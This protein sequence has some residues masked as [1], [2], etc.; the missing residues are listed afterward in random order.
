MF[1]KLISTSPEKHF[2]HEKILRKIFKYICLS[3]KILDNFKNTFY[4]SKGTLLAKIVLWK[5][6][7]FIIFFLTLGK[8]FSRWCSQ[9]DWHVS[10]ETCAI[11]KNKIGLIIFV[12]F[13]AKIF[14]WC[15]QKQFLSVQE[16]IL[17]IFCEK[18]YKFMEFFTLWEKNYWPVSEFVLTSH[19]VLT[20]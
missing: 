19:I 10:R 17:G 6:Y 9:T 4:L 15:S 3:R 14:G 18:I 12:E 5:S 1:S 2:D 11:L 13:W 8:N 16:N 7:E 20:F